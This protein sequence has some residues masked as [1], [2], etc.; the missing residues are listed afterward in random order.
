MNK[1]KAHRVA[2]VAPLEARG[3]CSSRGRGFS[4]SNTTSPAEIERVELRIGRQENTA[5][6]SA[7]DC[8]PDPSDSTTFPLDISSLVPD[9]RDASNDANRIR[10]KNTEKVTTSAIITV[11]SS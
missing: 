7:Q 11:Q 5:E 1:T 9:E 6:I 3:S 8:N 4:A 10:L 2:Q